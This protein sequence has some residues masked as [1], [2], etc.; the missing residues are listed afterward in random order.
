[1]SRVP[2][3]PHLSGLTNM[4]RD[5]VLTQSPDWVARVYSWDRA[6][7]TLGSS[8]RPGLSLVAG[9]SVPWVRRLTGGK[10]VLHGH[11]VTFGMS[12]PILKLG[13][14]DRRQVRSIYR[15]VL[16]PVIGALKDCGIDACLA[17]ELRAEI[18]HASSADCFVGQSS[19]DV[20]D[21]SSQQKI[22]GI[23]MRI[24][25]EKVFVQGSI[26]VRQ[27]DVNPAEIYSIPARIHCSEV[28]GQAFARALSLRL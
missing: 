23:A 24:L 28:D 25:G 16:Q 17:E 26:P 15:H 10:A 12:C 2:W 3:E 27:P 21:P 14:F 18:H 6:W 5:L 20:I 11:D 9:C 1:M 22:C 19:N 13:D 7:V 8:Q 4:A